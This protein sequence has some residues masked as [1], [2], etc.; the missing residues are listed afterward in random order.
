MAPRK[1]YYLRNVGYITI[2]P[3]NCITDHVAAEA[4]FIPTMRELAR[5]YQAFSTYFDQHIP[6]LDLRL[7]ISSF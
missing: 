1:V 4:P 6:T 2:Q 7:W 5:T 3:Q